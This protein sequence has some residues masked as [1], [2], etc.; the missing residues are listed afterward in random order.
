MNAM[1]NNFF[2]SIYNDDIIYHYTKASTAIDFIL[3]NNE[4]KFSKARNSYDPIESRK[5][6]RRTVSYGEDVGKVQ[7]KE[8]D[9]DVNEL[10][11]FIDDME[12]RFNFVC[13]CKNKKEKGS[14][15]ASKYYWSTF[16]GHEELFGFS[17]L[18]M[19]DQYADRFSGVCIAFSKEKI[20]SLNCE[21]FDI[22]E[23]DVQYLTFNKLSLRKVG[24]IQTRHLLNVGKEKYKQGLEKLLKESFFYKHI[25]YSGEAEYRIGT[26]F[27]KEKCSLETIRGEWILNRTMM[28]DI[29]GC[30]KAIFVSSY[31]NEKQ[32]KDL[33]Q[34]ANNLNVEMIE[35]EWNHDSFKPM[36]YKKK[37][38]F[39]DFWGLKDDENKEII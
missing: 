13:F 19:W 15:F 23:G 3:Y 17:K 24:D 33:L 39:Y 6:R 26:L 37:I 28:L 8:H 1:D 18:R 30:V 27:D 5:A 35:M 7:S 31:A 32:K 9:E 29:L 36:N 20:L 4:L 16:E 11:T 38:E 12:E 2:K 14:D 22:I 10:H 21:K 34:Y 25:D